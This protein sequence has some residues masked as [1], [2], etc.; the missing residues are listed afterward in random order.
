MACAQTLE[1]HAPL[2][3]IA[4]IHCV[5]KTTSVEEMEPGMQNEEWPQ[6]LPSYTLMLDLDATATTIVRKLDQAAATII[7]VVA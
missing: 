5:A 2:A 3:R 4:H 1:Y 7:C 6:E